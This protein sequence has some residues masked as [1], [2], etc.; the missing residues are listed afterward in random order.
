MN[1]DASA[2]TGA[3][4]ILDG[5]E[6]LMADFDTFLLDQ[7][8]VIHDGVVVHPGALE[9]MERLRDAGKTVIILSNSG[10][11]A[12]ESH[13]RMEKLGVTQDLYKEIVTSGELVYRN[14]SA[15]T[16]PFYA[17]LGRRFLMFAWDTDRGVVKDTGFEEVDT[18]E[19]AEFILCAGTDHQELAAYEPDLQAALKRG[20]PMIC[21]NPDRVSV[22]PDGSLKMCPGAVAE[23]YETMGGQVRWH[24]KP[25]AEV[26][27][28]CGEIAGSL[29]RAIGVG[30]SLIH[31][32][33]GA[34]DAGIPSLLICGG[35]HGEEIARPATA[36]A[37]ARVAG[38]YGAAP[39]YAA[40]LFRP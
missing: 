10:K 14:L 3:V 29:D 24:G 36:Q 8:G 28:V 31:D 19:E 13:S 26:Y 20:L 1:N 38:Q 18:V 33:K 6:L 25:T 21:A 27:R 30:D 12:N 11:R 16:D 17:G 37:V 9:A 39:T 34:N 32:I 5:I 4:T 22:Q 40:D 7:W 15:P 35:I 2:A 23:A